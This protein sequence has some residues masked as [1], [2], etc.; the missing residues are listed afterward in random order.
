MALRS[1]ALGLPERNLTG[2]GAQQDAAPA[3][4]AF[5][6]VEQH[7]GPERVCPLGCGVDVGDGHVGEP[8]REG[9]RAFDSAAP[10]TTTQVEPQIG[11]AVELDA[12]GQPAA[13]PRIERGR[14]RKVARVQLEV[15]ERLG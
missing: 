6:W 13:Q 15:D 14:P 8:S 11:P 1:S 12:L 4:R 2:R 3:G 7:R 10:D 5:A 9:N